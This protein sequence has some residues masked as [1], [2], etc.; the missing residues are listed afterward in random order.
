MMKPVRYI[1][2]LFAAELICA[3]ALADVEVDLKLEHK[4]YLQYEQVNAFVTIY[5][6]EDYLV[7]I[8]STKTNR[9]DE[10]RFN[11]RHGM[12]TPAVRINRLP[13]VD[14]LELKPG[15]KKTLLIDLTRWFSMSK[16]G[17]YDI[18]AELE[19]GG[20]VWRTKRTLIDI[21]DGIETTSVTR[22]IPGDPNRI[23]RYSL[24]YWAREQKEYLFLRAEE[25]ENEIVYGVFPLGVLIRIFKPV[26]DVDRK[27]N[28]TVVHQS[29]RNVFTRTTF[30]SEPYSVKFID[31]T[32]VNQEGSPYTLK[33]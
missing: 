29:G 27:G 8:D 23:R 6:D 11:I 17:S 15:A 21:V 22:S 32:Y 20:R 31:Q 7:V 1:C 16:V 18:S 33:E 25:E 9:L 30:R 14:Y 3:A 28:I 13:L 10:L 5:N 26:I 12:K 19:H 2:L 24:R 4:E